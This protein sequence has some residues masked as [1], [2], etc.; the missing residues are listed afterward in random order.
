MC[1]LQAHGVAAVCGRLP[2]WEN[3]S[4]AGKQQLVSTGR[5]AAALAWLAPCTLPLLRARTC[6]ALA[7]AGVALRAAAQQDGVGL[8]EVGQAAERILQRGKGVQDVMLARA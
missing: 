1:G 8:G 5:Q 2:A 3:N 7:H 4:R 6:D